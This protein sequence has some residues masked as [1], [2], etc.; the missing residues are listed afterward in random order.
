[1]SIVKIFEQLAR[2]VHHRVNFNEL[3][4]EESIELQQIFEN[5]DASSLKALFN[6]KGKPADRTTIFEL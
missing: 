1:M 3:L 2:T 4:K 5:N 6:E